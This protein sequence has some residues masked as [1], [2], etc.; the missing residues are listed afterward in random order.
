VK[1]KRSPFTLCLGAVVLV[2]L[3]RVAIGWHYF[4]EGVHKFDPAAEFSAE[5]FLGVAK[6][7]TA[8]LYYWMLPDYYGLQR[9]ELAKVKDESGKEFETFIVY[10]N[11]WKEY[12]DK[13]LE[14]CPEV[15]HESAKAI[16][17]QYLTS[18]RSG[19]ADV[20]QDVEAFLA[21]RERFVQT[22][23][24]IRNDAAF[25]QKRRWDIMA[26]YR[27]EAAG[28]TKMLTNMGNGLQSDLGRLLD[29]DLAGQKGEIVT[30]PEKALLPTNPLKVEL[31]L[32]NIK[33]TLPPKNDYVSSIDIPLR[34]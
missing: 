8:E 22:K 9:L 6:G 19:A 2:V 21:S 3:L 7:M 31:P 13:Y 25:E 27:S 28:W 18:L 17:N 16:Y 32:P 26:K 4:Y 34:S 14:K 29:P 30:G 11:A 33:L 10:E 12:F 1:N 20:K 23:K 24:D 15:K 5:G